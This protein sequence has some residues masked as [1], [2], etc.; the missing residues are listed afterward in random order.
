MEEHLHPLPAGTVAPPFTLPRSPVERVDLADAAG[1]PLVL[2]FYSGDWEPASS[3]QLD[4]LQRFLEEFERLDAVL[5]AI[6]P[7][8]VWC[9]GAFAQV[10][11]LR[12][13]L[14]ADVRPQGAVARAYG[15]WSEAEWTCRQAIFVI[16]GE[17]IIRWSRVYPPNLLPSLDAPLTVLERL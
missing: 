11:G 3:E 2:A 12:F 15:V 9:H 17:G 1:R 10:H 13:P 7:D 14:L 5:V 16:D 6:S 4:R 8:S